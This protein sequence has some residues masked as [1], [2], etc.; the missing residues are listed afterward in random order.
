MEEGETDKERICFRIK[1]IMA[2]GGR[3]RG[4]ARGKEGE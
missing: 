1:K 2:R 4:R 3:G